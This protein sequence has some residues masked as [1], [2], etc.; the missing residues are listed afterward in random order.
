MMYFFV[1]FP[2]KTLDIVKPAFSAMSVKLAIG[3]VFADSAPD[4]MTRRMRNAARL[5][6]PGSTRDGCEK[7]GF[8][9]QL[10]Y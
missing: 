5:P 3:G 6:A 8:M 7:A 2:P 10:E 4:V 9:T 1:S